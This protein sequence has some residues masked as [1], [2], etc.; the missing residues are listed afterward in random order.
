MKHEDVTKE[1]KC[2]Q[3]M[4]SY[5]SL[6]KGE[7]VPLKVTLHLLT[8]KVCRKQVKLLKTAEKIT[9]TPLEVPVPMDDSTIISIMSKIDPNYSE[10]KNPISIGKWIAAGI[11]MILF[12][13]TFGLSSYQEI[14]RGI[15]I[16]FYIFF[17]IAVTVYCSM[18]IGTNM[19]YF[20]KMINTKKIKIN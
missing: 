12:M 19:D 6:D 3:M 8:C 11:I 17:A 2:E 9:K 18:F 20:V 7:K 5:L 1:K 15:T 4:D 16:S 10:T 13:L 14:D